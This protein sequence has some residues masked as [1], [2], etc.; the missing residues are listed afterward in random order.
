MP[1]RGGATAMDYL[2]PTSPDPVNWPY[3][4]PTKLLSIQSTE[5][6]EEDDR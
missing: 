1:S 4:G 5:A 6:L 3:W 2:T